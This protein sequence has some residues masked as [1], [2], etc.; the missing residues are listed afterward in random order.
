MSIEP[1]ATTWHHF[2]FV[3]FHP[4][5]SAPFTD[6]E[7]QRQ[8]IGDGGSLILLLYER[9]RR[10]LSHHIP[11]HAGPLLSNFLLPFPLFWPAYQDVPVFC[12]A[13]RSQ[14]ASRTESG[15]FDL[16]LRKSRVPTGYAPGH[17]GVCQESDADL[18]GTSK[19][20]MRSV[21]LTG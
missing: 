10:L 9:R 6:A 2:L 7:R 14:P 16:P 1:G 15:A 5:P 11:P 20:F 17:G 4:P 3:N 8:H 19:S 12:K 21:G 13:L 18:L